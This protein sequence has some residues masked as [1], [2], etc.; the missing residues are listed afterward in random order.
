MSELRPDTCLNFPKARL[1]WSGEGSDVEHKSCGIEGHELTQDT[2]IGY[3]IDFL[4][5]TS[6]IHSLVM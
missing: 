5:I 3:Y 4:I 6:F 1:L 2:E